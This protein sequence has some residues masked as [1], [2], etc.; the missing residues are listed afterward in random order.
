MTTETI[1]TDWPTEMT[2]APSEEEVARERQYWEMQDRIAE[3]DAWIEMRAELES[4]DAWPLEDLEEELEIVQTLT[5][6]QEDVIEAIEDAIA[7]K[8]AA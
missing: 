1:T 6:D 2:Y 7:Q 3:Y 8:R 4:F 5:P